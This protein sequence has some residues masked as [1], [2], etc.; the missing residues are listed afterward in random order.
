M[1]ATLG[2]GI[3]PPGDPTNFTYDRPVAASGLA[4]PGRG[5]FDY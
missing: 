5:E 4:G 2:A 1:N 3:S